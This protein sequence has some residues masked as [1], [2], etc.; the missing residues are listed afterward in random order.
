MGCDARPK[1]KGWPTQACVQ[2]SLQLLSPAGRRHWHC[3]FLSKGNR[4][5]GAGSANPPNPWHQHGAMPVLER[6]ISA[7]HGAN[8]V[9]RD[10]ASAFILELSSERCLCLVEGTFRRSS[11]GNSASNG[12]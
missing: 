12:P 7:S 8:P 2:H 10:G 11:I 1:V 9:R 3:T 4:V 5:A 6:G